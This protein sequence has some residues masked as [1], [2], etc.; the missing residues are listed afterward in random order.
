MPNQFGFDLLPGE[1]HCIECDVRGPYGQWTEKAM[2]RHFDRHREENRLAVER[3]ARQRA[4]DARRLA[5]QA[6]RE[7]KTA[8]REREVS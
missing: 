8:Y 6:E 5:R 7:N 2:S 3:A 4:R 1:V